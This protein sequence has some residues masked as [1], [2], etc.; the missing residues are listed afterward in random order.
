VKRQIEICDKDELRFVKRRIKICERKKDGFVMQSE[1]SRAPDVKF[2]QTDFLVQNLSPPPL[3][4]IVNFLFCDELLKYFHKKK[5]NKKKMVASVRSSISVS[6]TAVTF[7]TSA[8]L[9]FG[10]PDHTSYLSLL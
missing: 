5:K 8:P 9:Q 3:L 2:T 7:R 6:T 1:R 4:M 10:N